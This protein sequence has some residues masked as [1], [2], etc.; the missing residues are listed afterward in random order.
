MLPLPGATC[1]GNSS[2]RPVLA[3]RELDNAAWSVCALPRASRSTLIRYGPL[4]MSLGW[5]GQE[6]NRMER[7][8]G[9]TISID[10]TILRAASDLRCLPFCSYFTRVYSTMSSA[11]GQRRAAPALPSLVVGSAA[12][13]AC[14]LSLCLPLYK[15][16]TYQHQ[17]PSKT[18]LLCCLPRCRAP[19]PGWTTAVGG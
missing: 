4:S 16:P 8:T 15:L 3:S 13:A 9:L 17:H 11:I 5:F 6:W 7:E 10:D 14:N 12:P 2:P 1:A 18:R 19:R